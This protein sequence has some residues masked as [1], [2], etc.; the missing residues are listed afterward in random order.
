MFT[1]LAAFLL[2]GETIRFDADLRP[3]FSER[4][5][6]A[7]AASTRAGF[8]RWAATAEGQLIIARFRGTDRDVVVLESID[9][10]GIGRA[11]Q[12]A[13]GTLLAAGDASKSKRYELIVNPA[14]AAQYGAPSIDLGLPRTPADVMAAA[15]AAEMLH[16]DFYARGIP[17][18]HHE[19]ADFQERWLAVAEQL[20]LPN[21][22]HGDEGEE[23]M[24]RRRP[25]G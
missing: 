5:Q 20:G 9:E 18:P 16:I 4:Q 12:P 10:S 19:R 21:T 3:Q 11:P 2:A 23:Q 8:A 17:L 14:L 6:T 25:G 7:S 13:L 22:E 15:W 1:L 24:E